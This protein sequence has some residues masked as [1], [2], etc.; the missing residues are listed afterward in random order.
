M[1]TSWCLTLQKRTNGNAKAVNY[2]VVAE[3]RWAT[4]S[5]QRVELLC[6]LLGRYRCSEGCDWTLCTACVNDCDAQGEKRKRD[7]EVEAREVRSRKTWPHHQDSAK[8]ARIDSEE[9][10]ELLLED[11]VSDDPTK[12][13]DSLSAICGMI[14]VNEGIFSNIMIC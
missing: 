7:E 1:N 10:V 3:M 8:K 4:Q 9:N 5:V 14:D 13:K 2:Q 12:V 6:S 11:I